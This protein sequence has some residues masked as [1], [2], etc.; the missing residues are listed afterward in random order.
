MKK[1]ATCLVLIGSLASGVAAMAA[2]DRVGIKE[3]DDYID[4][5]QACVNDKVPQQSRDA[6]T[7]SLNQMRSSW[8]AAASS[9]AAKDSLAQAC[10]QAKQTAK[11]TLSAYGCTN[12]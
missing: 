8:K 1:F 3:C 12:F 10:V 9:P 4:Q 7:T 11:A 5:Y 2:D 6:L